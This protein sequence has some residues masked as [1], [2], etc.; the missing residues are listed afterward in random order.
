MPLTSVF[1]GQ[2]LQV[3][4]QMEPNAW[5]IAFAIRNG[6]DVETG[7]IE[8]LVI[9]PEQKAHIRSGVLHES[10]PKWHDAEWIEGV[11]NSVQ[12]PMGNGGQWRA[13][14]NPELAALREDLA[15]VKERLNSIE[16]AKPKGRKEASLA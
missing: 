10:N 5:R 4:T 3:R 14:P 7:G 1:A 9:D 6:G 15:E 13:A 2:V 11:Y 16:S 8:V 12:I